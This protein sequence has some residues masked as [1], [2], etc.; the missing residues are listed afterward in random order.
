MYIDCIEIE[1]FRT[2][3]KTRIPFCHAQQDYSALG[4][5]KPRAA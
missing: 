3:R 1:H 4:F 5:P 2:F